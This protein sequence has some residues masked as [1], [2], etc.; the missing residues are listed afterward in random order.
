MYHSFCVEIYLSLPANFPFRYRLYF[1][2]SLCSSSASTVLPCNSR[3][4]I[5]IYLNQTLLAVKPRRNTYDQSALLT[6]GRPFEVRPASRRSCFAWR[7]RAS[8]ADAGAF[9]CWRPRIRSHRFRPPPCRWGSSRAA[10]KWRAF[11]LFL[12]LIQRADF[13]C[14]ASR[15]TTYLLL[16]S[17]VEGS[18]GGRIKNSLHGDGVVTSRNV[19]EKKESL[20]RR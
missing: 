14:E 5:T 7:A 13:A 4:P 20:V 8:A 17:R 15:P 11:A 19:V 10:Q 18:L 6:F 12:Y 1:I 16:R 2:D 9:A 3:M